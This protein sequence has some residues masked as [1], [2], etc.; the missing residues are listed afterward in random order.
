MV[1]DNILLS[2]TGDGIHLFSGS[3]PGSYPNVAQDDL[4]GFNSDAVVFQA[5][6]VAGGGLTSDG[7]ERML[8]L[9]F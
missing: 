7:D 8:N 1:N 6:A 9:E 5:D 4:V 2:D 3:I